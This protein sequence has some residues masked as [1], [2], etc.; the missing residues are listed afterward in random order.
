M[1]I[2]QHPPL[3]DG[4]QRLS[5]ALNVNL[6]SNNPFRNHTASPSSL[7]SEPSSTI[8]LE[9]KR[10]VS[11]NPFLDMSEEP[12]TFIHQPTPLS[13]K[14]S[15]PLMSGSTQQRSSV[16]AAAVEL[17]EN[18]KLDSGPRR[19]APSQAGNSN[20]K[21]GRKPE[22]VPPGFRGKLPPGPP[23]PGHRPSRSNEQKDGRPIGRMPEPR[24]AR[25]L[26]PDSRVR[27]ARR[28]RRNSDSSAISVRLGKALSPEERK[29]Q[30]E[31][32]HRD[33]RH[34]DG[35]HRAPGTSPK[36]KKPNHH[37]DI[38]DK[39]DVTSIY[40]TGLFHH[41]GP[42]DACN[43][44]RNRKGGSRAPMQAFPKDSANN[45]LG[46]SGPL[47][48]DIDHAQ[49]FGRRGA[50]AFADF[51]TSGADPADRAEWGRYD[52]APS[53]PKVDR[54]QSFNPT[55]RVDPVHGD[56]SLGLGTSTFLEGAPASR[57]AMKRR[58]TETEVDN[59]KAGGLSRT[60]SLAQRLRGI[61]NTRQNN[62]SSGRITSPEPKYDA[63]RNGPTSPN[64]LEPA[65]RPASAG[66]PTKPKESNPFFGEYDEAYDR[67]AESIAVAEQEIGKAIGPTSPPRS[68]GLQRKMT[69][70]AT[71]EVS[72]AKPSGFLSRVKSLK[73]GKRVRPSDRNA[74]L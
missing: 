13:P 24:Q 49:Y 60:K 33:R 17:F 55:N 72:E 62:G 38:I 2:A 42:F 23:P 32:R 22:N 20:F 57:T 10:P 8:A 15:M 12:H 41:D 69:N 6:S 25:Q 63:V 67:K 47:N 5:P 44:H 37:L 9:T 56:E 39:L 7:Q 50:D 1:S 73:G 31:R 52:G 65:F 27:D 59:M 35:R 51:S 43:P 66:G 4:D 53:R 21:S 48:R 71:P 64:G 36:P 70:E 29:R 18:L 54:S 28:M 30:E 68:Q 16:D 14:A 58:D 3:T 11:R 61:N 74:G 46:G 26:P 45:A 34:R 19:D 40:G